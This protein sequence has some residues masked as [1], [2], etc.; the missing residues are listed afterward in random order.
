MADLD[1]LQ[2]RIAAMRDS[3]QNQR[4]RNRQNSPEF[5]AFVDEYR[6]IFPGTKVKWVRWP[7]GSE[8]GKR[9]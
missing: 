6:Q 7:D 3:A 1:N 8:E 2:T 4:Q 9:T 5:T